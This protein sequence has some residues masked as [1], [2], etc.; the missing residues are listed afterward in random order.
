[1]N[2]KG[3]AIGGHT[4][5]GSVYTIQTEDIKC[6]FWNAS[7]SA[8]VENSNIQISFRWSKYD[9]RVGLTCLKEN[10]YQGNILCDGNQT[11]KAFFWLYSFGDKLLLKGDWEEDGWSDDCFIQLDPIV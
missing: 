9:Y 10:Y 8:L 2:Y 1:M 4:Q 5:N 6:Y 3:T 7:I 11:G